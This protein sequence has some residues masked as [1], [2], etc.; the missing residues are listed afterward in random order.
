MT[1]VRLVPAPGRQ[2]L[3]AAVRSR[4]ADLGLGLRVVAEGILG[5]D[6]PIDLVAL[7][8]DGGVVLVLLAAEG[9]DLELP[10][11]GLAQRSWVEARLGDWQQ[12][13]PRLGL[14][15]HAGVRLLLIA[16]DFG[17]QA[18][19]AARALG[20]AVAGL[21]TVRCVR[22]GSAI[23]VLLERIRST[24]APSGRSADDG[25]PSSRFRSGLGD[26]DLSLTP[27]E[28]RDLE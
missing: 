21:A 28:R 17:P 22:N 6:G 3:R 7:D 13:S 12:L 24:A 8:P 18:L 1:D 11:R 9:A 27:D 2:A 23:Q 5:A 4:L 19:A 15:P 25:T 16:P 10:G 20:P 26:S 14:T